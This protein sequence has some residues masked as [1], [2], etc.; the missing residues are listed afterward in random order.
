MGCGQDDDD[1]QTEYPLLM[2]WTYLVAMACGMLV[3]LPWVVWLIRKTEYR[4]RLMER[5]ARSA[6]R[7][8]EIGTMTSGLAHEIKNPLSTIGL[9]AQLI[10]EDLHEVAQNLPDQVQLR[11]HIGRIERRFGSLNREASRLRDILEDFLKFAGRM[12]LDLA[13]VNLNDLINELA[14][15]FLAQAQMSGIQVRTQLSIEPLIIQA[16]VS[17]LKQ[18]LLNLMINATQ[19]MVEARSNH[20]HHGGASELLI[21]TEKIRVLNQNEARIHIIDTGPGI[22]VDQQEKI[23]QPYFST[24]S[25]GT[26][27]GLPTTRRIIDEH[28]GT[29]NCYSEVG[30]GTEFSINLPMNP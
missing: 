15:F 16:D 13:P 26:G 18:A 6:E 8:A 2:M 4:V 7:L 17:L 14:D 19:A 27:L 30:R 29:I 28:H 23:F 21:R 12:K 10:Q 1:A 20:R 22:P 5:R 25:G 11:E 24:K 3:V 9:N